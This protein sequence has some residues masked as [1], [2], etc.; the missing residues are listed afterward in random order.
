MSFHPADGFYRAHSMNKIYLA[1]FQDAGENDQFSPPLLALEIPNN[2]AV[3]MNDHAEFSRLCSPTYCSMPGK[4]GS[5]AGDPYNASVLSRRNSSDMSDGPDGDDFP[6]YTYNHLHP[7]QS[8][9]HYDNRKGPRSSSQFDGTF[10]LSLFNQTVPN[11]VMMFDDRSKQQNPRADE[12]FARLPPNDANPSTPPPSRPVVFKMGHIFSNNDRLS[13]PVSPPAQLD[14]MTDQG[15]HKVYGQLKTV[16]SP[17]N[18]HPPSATAS[19]AVVAAIAAVVAAPAQNIANSANDLVITVTN[20]R[21]IESIPD[22]RPNSLSG[23]HL[24]SLHQ[25]VFYHL[26]ESK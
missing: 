13:V 19:N 16:E 2:R 21:G 20:D 10:Q 12:F 7:A 17:L 9:D 14:Q 11:H 6:V 26:D 5:D 18:S 25:S 8:T 3:T 22:S 15:D 4:K 24:S 1:D 23:R